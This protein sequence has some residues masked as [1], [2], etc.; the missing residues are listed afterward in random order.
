MCKGATH[1]GC[2]ALPTPELKAAPAMLLAE[3]TAADDAHFPGSHIIGNNASWGTTVNT[4][5]KKP[6]TQTWSLC[7]SS[8]TDNHATPATFHKQCDSHS[9]TAVFVRNSIG[10][11]FGGYVRGYSFPFVHFC[12]CF[13]SMPGLQRCPSI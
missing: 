7:F 5:A 8:I 11:V 12:R 4:W 13:P 3:H 2:P 6:A 9:I 10:N 1:A